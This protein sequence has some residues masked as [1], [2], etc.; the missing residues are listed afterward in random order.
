MPII[1]VAQGLEYSLEIICNNILYYREKEGGN[2]IKSFKES[3]K[4]VLSTKV[5][6]V[7]Q[8]IVISDLGGLDVGQTIIE[9]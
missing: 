1:C 7:M 9:N 2:G 6:N 5:C 4:E 3:D 8:T